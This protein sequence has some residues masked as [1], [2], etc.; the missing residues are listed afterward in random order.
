MTM[1]YF[2]STI[3]CFFY[4]DLIN[5]QNKRLFLNLNE[6]SFIESNSL[7]GTNKF[8]YMLSLFY[9]SRHTCNRFAETHSHLELSNHIT[10]RLLAAGD[11]IFPIFRNNNKAEIHHFALNVIYF[12]GNKNGLALVNANGYLII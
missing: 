3:D 11:E 1:R 9:F 8:L 2:C 4:H 5:I 7:L 12:I 6:Y 10:D